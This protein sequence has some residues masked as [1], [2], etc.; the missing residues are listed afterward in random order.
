MNAPGRNYKAQLMPGSN[1]MQMKNDSQMELEI[2][3]IFQQGIDA[4]RGFFNTDDR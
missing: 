2:I 1:H 4:G 3:R